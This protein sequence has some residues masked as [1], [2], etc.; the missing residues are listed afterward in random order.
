MADNPAPDS[1]AT[2]E[3]L[4][5]T[6]RILESG[7]AELID[8]INRLVSEPSPVD[9]AEIERVVNEAA[10]TI[11]ASIQEASVTSWLEILASAAFAAVIAAFAAFLFNFL[12]WRIVRRADNRSQCMK[13][14]LSQI[15]SF[16]KVSTEYWMQPYSVKKHTELANL[17]ATI[18]SLQLS[19]LSTTTVL[20]SIRKSLANEEHLGRELREFNEKSFDIVT[21]GDFGSTARAASPTT[22]YSM[23]SECNYMKSLLN[24]HLH[25]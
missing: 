14:L 19:I 7:M 24:L 6:N 2:I 1:A 16:E 8:E 20:S 22:A 9:Y 13:L 25:S 12:N 15:E 23:M 5:D 4:E 11:S 3:L 21:G 18:K 10:A 17:Q